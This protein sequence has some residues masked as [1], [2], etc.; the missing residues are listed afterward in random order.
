MT[1]SVKELFGRQGIVGE[2]ISVRNSLANHPEGSNMSVREAHG[3]LLTQADGNGFA[4]A[5]AGP[6]Q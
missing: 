6:G 1:I 3:R 2:V 5:A 4:A